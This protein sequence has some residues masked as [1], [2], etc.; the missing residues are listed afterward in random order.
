MQNPASILAIF[1]SR[2]VRRFTECRAFPTTANSLKANLSDIVGPAAPDGSPR[3]PGLRRLLES[4]GASDESPFFFSV[5]QLTEVRRPTDRT[6]SGVPFRVLGR[7]LNDFLTA[8]TNGTWHGHPTLPLFGLIHLMVSNPR[9]CL[10]LPESVSEDACK[11]QMGRFVRK[12]EAWHALGALALACTLLRERAQIAQ[13]E[14]SKRGH[15]SPMEIFTQVSSHFVRN[16]LNVYLPAGLEPRHTLDLKPFNSCI[17]AFYAKVPTITHPFTGK[18][19]IPYTHLGF[20]FSEGHERHDF[21]RA[22]TLDKRAPTAPGFAYEPLPF[23]DEQIAIIRDRSERQQQQRSRRRTVPATPASPG[24]SGNIRGLPRS[25]P[26]EP[27]SVPS[28]P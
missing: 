22:F 3:L 9:A 18:G 26:T 17:I 15:L 4:L 13:S 12:T 2:G 11:R 7:R 24:S 10:D 19:D 28:P 25:R 21:P 20:K 16:R 1:W 8:H 23:T 5:S 27:L 6:G 14:V